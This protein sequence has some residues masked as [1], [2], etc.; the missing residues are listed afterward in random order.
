V[1]Q[2][3]SFFKAIQEGSAQRGAALTPEI[4]SW[5]AELAADLLKSARSDRQAWQNVPVPGRP[6]S[7][8]PWFLQKRISADG[9]KDSIFI[10][11]LPPGG[12]HLTGVLRS[13]PFEI[14]ERIS[15]YLAGHDGVPTSK[16]QG[17]NFIRLVSAENAQILAQT[18]PPR[19][20]TAQEFHWDLKEFKG[21]R[22]RIEIVD[23]DTG[24]A[25]AWIAAGRFEPNV[26]P[27]PAI[28]P[29]QI[30][31]RLQSAA[32]LARTLSLNSLAP[33]MGTLLAQE[34][35][36]AEAQAALATALVA[37]EPNEQRIALAPL[38]GDGSIPAG[39]R[40][41]IGK[42]LA[43]GKNGESLDV[44]VEAMRVVPARVQ[45]RLAQS[46]AGSATGAQTLFAMVEKRQ[47]SPRVLLD[48]GVQDK[49]NALK[50]PELKAKITTLT[51]NLEPP[52]EAVQKLIDTKRKGFNPQK[53]SPV[54]GA[55][56]FTKNC[57]IC[58]QIDGNG[59][60][61]GP[62]L[63]GVGSRGLERILEDV[64][65]P[66]RNVDVNFRTHILVLKEGDV[67][68]GLFRREEGEL[69]VIAD[70]T[71]KEISVPKKGIESRRESET[72]LM[73]AN[74]GD[75]ISEKDFQDLMAYLLS[76]GVP[77]GTR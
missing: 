44:L 48:R 29:N 47:A 40:Q 71:G 22:A 66:N 67:I 58:H 69:M 13:S 21:Q 18:A 51:E 70:S 77:V 12:E 14:P 73:P 19:N 45:L 3:L 32:E 37:L 43:A 62:Q 52:A 60:L 6:I 34:N 24:P 5:G 39:L 35:M 75:I 54:E 74:F 25:Y 26:A 23:G 28:N 63:D 46:L 8:N 31:A 50:S 38:L 9:D 15:F 61:I 36:D 55:K 27:L 56:V 42:S 10:C 16:P 76:K 41:K 33:E 57:A 68:S 17:N 59:A 1:D 49:V 7:A 53:A 65:D 11:S 64:L 4:Q 2:Q 30:S 20:D 72:S